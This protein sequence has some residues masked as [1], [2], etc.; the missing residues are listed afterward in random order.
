MN[1]EH[2]KSSTSLRGLDGSF[3]VGR[4]QR[5]V[6]NRIKK[7]KRN[8][9]FLNLDF[10]R[11]LVINSSWAEEG[12]SGQGTPEALQYRSESLFHATTIRFWCVIN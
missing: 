7:K 2:D 12:F 3:H 9:R 5:K 4:W 8:K 6:S 10:I 11:Y 1:V